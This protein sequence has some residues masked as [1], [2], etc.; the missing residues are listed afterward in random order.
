MTIKCI[1]RRTA[2]RFGSQRR[3]CSMAT[4][5]ASPT[6]AS[7]RPRSWSCRSRTAR[8][9]GR[10]RACKRCARSALPCEQPRPCLAQAFPTA[11]H[12]PPPSSAPPRCWQRVRGAP[13]GAAPA[14]RRRLVSHCPER[15]RNSVAT[16]GRTSHSHSLR[17]P[18]GRTHPRHWR[19]AVDKQVCGARDA[20][21]TQRRAARR[22][23]V[24]LAGNDLAPPRA[25]PELHAVSEAAREAWLRA[26]ALRSSR[27]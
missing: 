16:R 11:S 15:H 24:P 2:R 23:G 27:A 20:H 19:Q 10:R 25:P 5:R 8:T 6:P 4:R 13:A 17:A 21:V 1:G 18:E 12:P 26:R 3:R 7:P 22:Y 14:P 9:C